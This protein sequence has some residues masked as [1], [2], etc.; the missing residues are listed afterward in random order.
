MIIQLLP[1]FEDS[2]P[3]WVISF[4]NNYSSD[5]LMRHTED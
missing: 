2:G 3:I 5:I 1:E 4:F